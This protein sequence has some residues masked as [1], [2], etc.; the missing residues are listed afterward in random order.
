MSK[1]C[2]KGLD[3]KLCK[4]KMKVHP[5][6]SKTLRCVGE[7]I[8]TIMHGSKVVNA[9][10]YVVK[11][12]VETLLSGEVCE[13]LGIIEFT[14]KPIRRATTNTCPHKTR[15]ASPFPKVFEDRVGRLK[16]YQVK[17]YVDES[18]APVAERRRPVPFHLR[19]KRNQALDAMEAEGLIEEHHGPAPWISNTVLS[20]KDDGRTRVTCD[21]QKA[22]KA[23][24]STN[25]PIPRVEEIKS[26]LSGSKVFS[27]LDFKSAFHQLEI[28]EGSRYLTVFHGNGRCNIEC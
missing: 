25:I 28:D 14:P 11:Q 18:V 7:Y 12:E 13:A 22:N 23:I 16:N 15:L 9:V 4:T 20:P 2:A 19:E 5:Y 26:E 8:G 10:I 6:G 3:L 27:K 24:Q 21:M 17:F 1:K